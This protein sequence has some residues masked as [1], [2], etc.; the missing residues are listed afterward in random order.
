MLKVQVK[1]VSSD[2]NMNINIMSVEGTLSGR[3]DSELVTPM[4]IHSRPYIY[5]ILFVLVLQ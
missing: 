2:C 5:I 1:S 4:L 3:E